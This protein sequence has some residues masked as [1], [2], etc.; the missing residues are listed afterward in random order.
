CGCSPLQWKIQ[1]SSWP[2]LSV[3]LSV[4]L[5][6]KSNSKMFRNFMHSRNLDRGASA[7]ISDLRDQRKRCRQRELDDRRACVTTALHATA[8]D[9]SRSNEDD[10]PASSSMVTTF[11]QE[12][13]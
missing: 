13:E 2:F 8:V 7:A 4:L 11:A 12:I 5:N 10:R 6:N 3:F 1:F 9:A